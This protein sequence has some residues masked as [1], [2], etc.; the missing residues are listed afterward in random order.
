[1]AVVGDLIAFAFAVLSLAGEWKRGRP[2]REK[3]RANVAVLERGIKW[4]YLVNKL[5]VIREWV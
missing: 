1:M 2:G 5:S 4:I 3:E